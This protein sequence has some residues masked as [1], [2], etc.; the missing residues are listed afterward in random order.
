MKRLYIFALLGLVTLAIAQAPF[1]IR[2]SKT[3]PTIY[4]EGLD[5][6]IEP[7][8]SFELSGKVVVKQITDGITMTCS[9][10]TG[11]LVKVGSATEMD[12]VKLTGG[13]KV[14]KVS[15]DS[16]VN[17]SGG[18]GNYDLKGDLRQITLNSNVSFGFVGTEAKKVGNATQKK[19]SDMT[20][21]G[22]SVVTTF[23]KTKKAGTQKEIAE[24]Q[25]ATLQ[26]PITFSGTQISKVDDKIKTSKFSAKADKMTYSA[27]GSAGSPEIVLTGKN[28]EITQSGDDDGID[29]SGAKVITLT[30]NSSNEIV[31]IKFSSGGGEQ[32]KTVYTKDGK[33]GN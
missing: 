6:T 31:R 20:A 25:S 30:L 32:V 33:G 14:T 8:N 9:K 16:T 7:D 4:I 3:N 21:H 11:K 10:V 1:V 26:G 18:S 29:V 2:D 27:S 17:V 28:I 13:V 19:D 22:S 12:D 24:I 15:A 5:G 23:K